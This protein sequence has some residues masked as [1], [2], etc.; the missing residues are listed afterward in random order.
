ME[1]QNKHMTAAIALA[2]TAAQLGEVPVAARQW[3]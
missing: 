3:A 2:E 1:P